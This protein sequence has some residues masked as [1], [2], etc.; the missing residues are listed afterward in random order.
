MKLRAVLR[1][2]S[3]LSVSA[4]SIDRSCLGAVHGTGLLT[5]G[6]SD[7]DAPGH[8][9]TLD[10]GGAA[11]MDG[12]DPVTLLRLEEP[13]GRAPRGIGRERGG[14]DRIQDRAGHPEAGGLAVVRELRALVRFRLARVREIEVA[15]A[16][17][18]GD[19]GLDVDV[20]E[21]VAHILLLA[22]RHAVALGLLTIAKEAIPDAIA[23]DPAAAAVLEL[24]VRRR[25]RPALV[26][27]PDQRER[28]HADV[29]EEDRLLDPA[30]GPTLAA[31]PHQLHRLHGDP[32]QIRVDHEPGEVLV[33]P[34]LR[35][36][37]DDHPDPVGAVVAADEDLLAL[38]H[39]LVAVAHRGRHSHTGQIG[40]GAGL[41]QELPRADLAAIDRRQ[42]P[43]ALLLRAPDEDRGRAEPAAAVVIRRQREVEAIDLLLEAD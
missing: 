29:V 20:G 19:L 8:L 40:A 34:A 11:G 23:T 1:S 37:A 10:V 32:G 30:V 18:P 22:E 21:A 35:V 12:D 26:L 9:H 14:A 6:P 38:D 7:A 16:E 3:W 43:L 24:E 28:R 36:R 5:R 2:I 39:V 25:D 15:Q 42:E 33:A 17:E 41:G 31:G 13:G 4:R 27:A